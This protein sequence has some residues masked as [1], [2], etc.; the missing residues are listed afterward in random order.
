MLHQEI[1]ESR[2]LNYTN[3]YGGWFVE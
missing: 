2:F 3:I 1:D